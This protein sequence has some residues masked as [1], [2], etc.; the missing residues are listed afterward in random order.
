M[1]GDLRYLNVKDTGG[2]DFSGGADFT[3]GVRRAGGGRGWGYRRMRDRGFPRT[4]SER[5]CYRY[6]QEKAGNPATLRGALRSTSVFH[7]AGELDAGI[8]KMFTRIF[9]DKQATMWRVNHIGVSLN[10]WSGGGRALAVRDFDALP[11]FVVL[12]AFGSFGVINRCDYLS[13]LR[14]GDRQLRSEYVIGAKKF[15]PYE[16]RLPK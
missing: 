3:F 12:R 4:T 6:R 7:L 10:F 8:R 16:Y 5:Q 15:P 13:S 2:F 14:R 1:S 11:G 9:R